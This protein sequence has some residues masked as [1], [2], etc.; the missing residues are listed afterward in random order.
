[1]SLIVCNLA[2]RKRIGSF[3]NYLNMNHTKKAVSSPTLPQQVFIGNIPRAVAR[4]RHHY[5]M[6][7]QSS[8]SN[9]VPVKGE[10]NRR[11]SRDDN[12]SITQPDYL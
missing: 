4:C 12:I 7:I 1:M 3:I 5:H 2:I 8:N 9:Q 10:R 6:N 11:V